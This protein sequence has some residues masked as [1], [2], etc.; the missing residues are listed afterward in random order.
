MEKERWTLLFED[1]GP[2]VHLSVKTD[3]F[4]RG[5][6]TRQEQGGSG[7]GLNIVRTA[8]ENARGMISLLPNSE[9]GGATFK[10]TLPARK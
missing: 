4:E 10:V 1:S 3:L 2:G 5:V 9:L 7:L 8:V 6:T